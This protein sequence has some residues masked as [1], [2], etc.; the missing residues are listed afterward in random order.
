MAQTKF[1]GPVVSDNGFV[2][3]VTGNVTGVVTL[4]A[5]TVSTVP[6]AGAGKVVYVSNGANGAP[7]VAFAN[8]S[9]WFRCDTLGALSAT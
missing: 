2:G 9:T 4:A 6:A 8:A 7:V 1:S 5:Y 3:A